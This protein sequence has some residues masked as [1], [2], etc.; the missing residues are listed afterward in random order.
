VAGAAAVLQAEH[1]GLD[2][3]Q[4]T[5]LLRLTASSADHWTAG[6][7]FGMLDVSAALAAPLPAPEPGE[8]DDGLAAVRGSR[9]SSHPLSLA[10]TRRATVTGRVAPHTDPSDV[11]RVHLRHGDRLHATLDTGSRARLVLTLWSPS[12]PGNAVLRNG[13]G[14]L[15]RSTSGRLT[16]PR[17]A[18]NGTYYVSVTTRGAP[19]A[20]VTYSVALRR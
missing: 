9:A 10:R 2:V 3:A 19:A 4:L 12:A 20:G 11:L 16:S 17:I 14:R 5:D 8:V 6:T 1:P 15:A 7:G 13:P 18:K